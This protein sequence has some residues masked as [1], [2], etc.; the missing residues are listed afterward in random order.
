MICIMGRRI[1]AA[2]LAAGLAVGVVGFET[3]PQAAEFARDHVPGVVNVLGGVGLHGYHEAAATG[4]L[5]Q[6][7]AGLQPNQEMSPSAGAE[8]TA[9]AGDK[10]VDLSRLRCP[11]GWFSLF[12]VKTNE[13]NSTSFGRKFDHP[14]KFPPVLCVA[15]PRSADDPHKD[16]WSVTKD[17]S[18]NFVVSAEVF[19]PSQVVNLSPC[20]DELSKCLAATSGN[21]EILADEAAGGV[22]DGSTPNRQNASGLDLSRASTVVKQLHQDGTVTTLVTVS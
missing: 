7:A 4:Q 17:A 8:A 1:V 21:Q 9:T 13:L 16:Q 20:G 10:P 11:V 14:N 22:N 15:T 18:G 6:N 19:I 3:S 12:P 5:D 2:G